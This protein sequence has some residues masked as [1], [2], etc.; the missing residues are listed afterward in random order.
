[1]LEIGLEI[2]NIGFYLCF[3]FW[4]LQWTSLVI[5]RSIIY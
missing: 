4:H 3:Y 2:A 1:M 5:G